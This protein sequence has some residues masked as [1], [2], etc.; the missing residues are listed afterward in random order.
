M[1]NPVAVALIGSS[2][3][4]A[5]TITSGIEIVENIRSH[6]HAIQGHRKVTI[7]SVALIAAPC[8]LDFADGRGA[9]ASLWVLDGNYY[10]QL[11]CACSSSLAVCNNRLDQ[12]DADLASRIRDGAIDAIISISSDPE[13]H[14]QRS[15]AAA[16]EAGV[17]IVGTGGTSISHVATS[18]GNV[19]GCSGGSVATTA[20]TRGICFAASIAAHFGLRYTLP[21]PPVLAKFRSVVGAALPLFLAVACL[22]TALPALRAALPAG[23]AVSPGL[24]PFIAQLEYAAEAVVLPVAVAALT[25][26]EVSAVPDLS[27]LTGAAAGALVPARYANT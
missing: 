5:A 24:E 13:R 19:I 12:A 18:G 15:F 11:T 10:N 17:P 16:I 26:L 20:A 2:G 27:L 4:G 23:L 8:G 14:N 3:G 1:F 9:A 6:L 21:R 7:V 25:C 22:R